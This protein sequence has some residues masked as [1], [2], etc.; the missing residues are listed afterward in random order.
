MCQQDNEEKITAIYYPNTEG[1]IAVW[2]SHITYLVTVRLHN[3]KILNNKL[4]YYFFYPVIPSIYHS[5][6]SLVVQEKVQIF[7]ISKFLGLL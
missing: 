5:A 7:S 2:T 3:Q 1:Q 6:L 4:I